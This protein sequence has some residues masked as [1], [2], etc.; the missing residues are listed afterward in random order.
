QNFDLKFNGDEFESK[1]PMLNEDMSDNLGD[2]DHMAGDMVD[3]GEE[4]EEAVDKIANTPPDSFEN[5]ACDEVDS[6]D[7]PMLNEYL[8]IYTSGQDVIS[9]DEIDN[10][11][12]DRE[13]VDRDANNPMDSSETGEVEK[14]ITSSRNVTKSMKYTDFMESDEEVEPSAKKGRSES[15]EKK[16]KAVTQKRRS[17]SKVESQSK[18]MRMTKVSMD[19]NSE[20]KELECPECELR[21][22][23]AFSWWYHLKVKHS[24]TPTLAGCLLRCDCGNE[25]YSF[26]HSQQIYL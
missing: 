11:G 12:D 5:E 19:S 4:K 26:A 21:A 9:S 22:D 20:K 18:T 24:T 23:S 15:E 14:R 7:E 2:L 13:A 25:S 6:V 1:E 3:N 16:D 10:G 17:S 8:G